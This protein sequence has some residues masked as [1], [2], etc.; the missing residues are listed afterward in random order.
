[1]KVVYCRPSK[2]GRV[3]FGD[4]KDGALQPYGKYW[5]LGANEATEITFSKNVN[6]AGQ[7]VNAGTYTMYAVPGP[8]TWQVALNSDIQKWGYSEPD[9]SKDVIKVEVPVETAPDM[10]QFTITFDSD[11][12][13]AKMNFAWATALVKVPITIQ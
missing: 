5:R 3:I 1:M 10:E 4:A 13:A 11:S 7:P 12:T 2:K 6:F 9:Y 8:S